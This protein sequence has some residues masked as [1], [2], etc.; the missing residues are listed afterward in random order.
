MF[1]LHIFIIWENSTKFPS[2]EPTRGCPSAYGVLQ[3]FQ[4]GLLPS[5]RCKRERRLHAFQPRFTLFA[6]GIHSFGC[7]RA[8]LAAKMQ[9]QPHRGGAPTLKASSGMSSDTTASISRKSYAAF[10]ASMLCSTK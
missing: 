7:A 3:H 2:T 10:S 5:Q 4:D 8:M 6:L 9:S 1:A